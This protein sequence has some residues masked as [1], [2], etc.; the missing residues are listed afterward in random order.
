MA[1]EICSLVQKYLATFDSP[2]LYA[3]LT[4]ILLF[5]SLMAS[6]SCPSVESLNSPDSTPN[7][8]FS[9]TV[10]SLKPVSSKYLYKSFGY[11]ISINWR[12]NFFILLSYYVPLA[13]QTKKRT[14]TSLFLSSYQ[15]LD[16]PPY[17]QATM[18]VSRYRVY[19]YIQTRYEH[20][21][22]HCPPIRNQSV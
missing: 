4:A 16:Y 7:L 18:L 2:Y 8:S 9:K 17:E 12:S 14:R 5:S 22:C 15:V 1:L 21:R 20:K 3:L 6:H 13:I 11:T 10:S 19:D